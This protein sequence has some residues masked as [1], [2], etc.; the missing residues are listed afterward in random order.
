V[1]TQDPIRIGPWTL[2]PSSGELETG[3]DRVRLAPKV[4]ALLALL[5]AEP[6]RVVTREEITEALWPGV[7]VGE[8]SLARL[9]SKLRKALGDDSKEPRY[10]ET[11]PKRGYRLAID[12]I[13]AVVAE[14]ETALRAETTLLVAGAG[15]MLLIAAIFYFFGPGIERG[16]QAP[17]TTHTLMARADDFYFQ[18]TR[19]DN[20]AAI[21]IYERIL[22]A[23]PD[24]PQAQAG[25]ANA[26]VQ[27][28]MRWPVSSEDGRGAITTL[29][30]AHSSGRLAEPAARRHIDRALIL[31]ADAVRLAPR[32][33]GA[34]KALGLAQS[35]AGRFDAALKSY[36]AALS[37]DPDAWGVL[38][39]VGDVLE[40]GGKDAD[41]LPYFEQA[42]DAMSKAYVAE[43]AR[44]RPWQARLGVG[45]ARRRAAAGDLAGSETWY[46]RVLAVAPLDD[47]A[48]WELAAQLRAG[49]SVDEADRLCRD[50]ATRTG[51][52]AC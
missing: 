45:I 28:A 35:A 26:L 51:G 19:E 52:G 49:G 11:L 6:G 7:T 39:N 15:L 48:T 47:E 33:A 9:V 27:R 18:Y 2:D 30:E 22:A 5:A 3:G 37:V 40:I 38:I 21:A 46:R 10:I 4:S 16:R 24:D 44:V 41:A 31:A 34:H 50:R 29:G 36:E 42:Y 1:S 43:A 14:P 12:A 17:A 13:A 20:E 8:D 25:L 32:D 23:N